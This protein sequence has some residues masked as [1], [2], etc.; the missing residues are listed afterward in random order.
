MRTSLDK[1]ANI[2]V[3]YSLKVEKNDRVLITYQDVET[4]ELVKK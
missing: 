4:N 1:L 3:N 2:I